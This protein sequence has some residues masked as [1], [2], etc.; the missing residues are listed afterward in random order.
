M[1]QVLELLLAAIRYY[2]TLPLLCFS[3]EIGE[4]LCTSICFTEAQNLPTLP[5]SSMAVGFLA[6][7]LFVPMPG[8][9]EH[10]F[11]HDY[12]MVFSLQNKQQTLV[13][14]G[15]FYALSNQIPMHY[16]TS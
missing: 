16:S 13:I 6:K 14:S 15:S 3:C 2:T 9:L 1:T 12:L 4:I 10:H 8:L 11:N 7:R 5:F